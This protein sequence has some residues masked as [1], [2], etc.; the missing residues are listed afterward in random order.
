MEHSDADREL[1]YRKI[2]GWGLA[3]SALVTMALVAFCAPLSPLALARGLVDGNV[4][5]RMPGVGPTTRAEA[6]LEARETRREALRAARDARREALDAVDGARRGARAAS[7][8]AR[9]ATADAREEA[10]RALRDAL[11]DL[12]EEI[13]RELGSGLEIGLGPGLHRMGID[14]RWGI[15]AAL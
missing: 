5:V 1:P 9:A 8:E 14:A 3:A 13:S 2:A 7:G 15:A 12:D 11:R 4:S 6:R 10:R